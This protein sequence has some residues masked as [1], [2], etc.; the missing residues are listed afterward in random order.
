[1][2]NKNM[3]VIIALALVL[4]VGMYIYATRDNG[5][6]LIKD[7]P[8]VAD[9]APETPENPSPPETPTTPETPAKPDT[10][11]YP[12]IAVGEL[13]PD[14]TLKNLE[15]EEVSLS[16]Y[17]GKI[18]MINFWATW[19]TWCDVEMPD[20]QKLS[21]E[22]DD[23]VVLAVDVQED[24]RD[25]KKYIEDGGYDFEVVLDSDGFVNRAYLVNGLPNSY[26]VDKEGILLGK[27]GGAINYAQMNEIL[28]NI[29][30]DQ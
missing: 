20:M 1:M 22:N 16:D 12:D 29:R 19:C 28:E 4:V 23:L 27:V 2:K 18:V 5:K 11:K 15:G 21:S 8:P 13:A 14:F 24:I 9:A 26:F 17:K 25:V 3:I 30:K 7:E 10:T 6:V